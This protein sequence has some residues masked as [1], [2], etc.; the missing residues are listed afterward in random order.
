MI[1]D[2][3]NSKKIY[4]SLLKSQIF[5]PNS[6]ENFNQIN[7]KRIRENEKDNNFKPAVEDEVFFFQNDEIK[8]NE[9]K[10]RF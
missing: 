9:I 6:D 1:D 10:Q 5:K 7:K 8:S 3:E 2:K 4:L